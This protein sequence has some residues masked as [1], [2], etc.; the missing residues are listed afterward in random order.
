[1]KNRLCHLLDIQYP[2]IQ[3]AMQ[4]LSVPELASAVSNAGGL[5]IITAATYSSKDALIQAIRRMKELTGKPFAVNV[6][7]LAKPTPADRSREYIEAI[8]EE[9]V[10]IV[11]TSGRNPEEF[12]GELKSA[13]IKVMHKVPSVRFAKKAE[14]IGVDAITI[15]SYECGGHP[16]M[17]EATSM[18]QI[19]KA[20]ME[21]SVPIIAGGGIAD[22]NGL[23]A[24]LALGADGVVMGTRFIASEECLIHAKFKDV[25]LTSSENDTVMI[26]RS[27]RNAIRTKSNA[28]TDKVL[29]LEA[30]GATL[31]E[32]LN[33][34]AGVIAKQCYQTGDTE[35][36]VFPIGQST[37]LVNE[38]KPVKDIVTDTMESARRILSNLN[39]L[40]S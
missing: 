16:G 28:T 4:W 7:L 21:L 10:S 40:Y 8:L 29:K 31:S 39:A 38:I 27:I 23:A 25:V 26:Q 32:L 18:V 14:Q 2:I 3:G 20:A 11:E 13:G 22:G 15:V 30:G 12:I 1:M 35:G 5:G 19:R 37:G 36:C 17:G 34:T 6:S 33:L 24:A 9:K